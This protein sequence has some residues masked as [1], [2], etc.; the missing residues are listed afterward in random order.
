MAHHAE[1]SAASFAIDGQKVPL[2][3]PVELMKD[4]LGP[5]DREFGG[6]LRAPAGHRN[7]IRYIYDSAG[8][9]LLDNWTDQRL[10]EVTFYFAAEPNL[11][12]SPKEAWDGLVFLCASPVNS[13]HFWGMVDRQEDL[14]LR[15]L[16]GGIYS[17][18]VGPLHVTLHMAR[19]P[20]SGDEE[21][22]VTSLSASLTQLHTMR[23]KGGKL[24]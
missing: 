16:V 9:S 13:R 10:K 17:A 8:I 18:T 7:N 24:R 3:Q 21:R 4:I 14:L 11:P 19:E 12:Y 22:F 23:S 2:G 6:S 20:G 15:P 5:W 1:L